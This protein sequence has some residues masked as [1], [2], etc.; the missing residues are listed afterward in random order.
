MGWAADTAV[1][2]AP[3]LF[4][5]R[6]VVVGDVPTSGITRSLPRS[7]ARSRGPTLIAERVH[8]LQP[9]AHLLQIAQTRIATRATK[10]TLLGML[11]DLRTWAPIEKPLAARAFPIR[12]SVVRR[13]FVGHACRGA[14]TVPHERLN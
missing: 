1:E 9:V 3:A 10:R 13:S 7:L 6:G 8:N 5:I 11:G 12:L 2:S 14:S 4:P